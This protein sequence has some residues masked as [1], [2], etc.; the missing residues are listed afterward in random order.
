MSGLQE[1]L[2]SRR[3]HRARVEGEE[4]GQE[5]EGRG[6]G[7]EGEDREGEAGRVRRAN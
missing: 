6:G 2:R 4:V 3:E 5:E 1:R 7:V